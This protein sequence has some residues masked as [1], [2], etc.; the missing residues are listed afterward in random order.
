LA[1]EWRRLYNEELH[2]FDA[3]PN[4]REITLRRMRLA[5]HITRMGER[6]NS[7]TFVEKCEGKL[8]DL[9]KDEKVILEG[10]L[11]K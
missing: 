9:V 8:Q 6:R 1:G 11:G 5:G 3:S 2:D 10:I 4:I 7:Y